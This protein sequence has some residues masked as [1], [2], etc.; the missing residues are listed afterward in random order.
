MKPNPEQMDA[1]AENTWESST[2][3]A[4]VNLK[5]DRLP[6]TRQFAAMTSGRSGSGTGGPTPHISLALSYARAEGLLHSY[7]HITLIA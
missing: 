6:V 2:R 5:A 1:M 3:R 4:E 7:M